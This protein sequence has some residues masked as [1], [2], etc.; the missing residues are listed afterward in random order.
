[1]TPATIRPLRPEDS[2]QAVRVFHDA[3]MNG[4][5]THY[6]LAQR[7]AWA[8]PA[9]DI[10]GWRNRFDGIDGFAAEIGGKLVGFMTLDRDGYIDLAFVHSA[11]AGQG[12][13][14]TLHQAIVA[15][16]QDNGIQTLTT[17]ASERAMPF[18]A[19]LGWQV[20][21]RQRVE[22]RGVVLTNYRMSKRLG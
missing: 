4:A 21:Q 15:K 3:I 1:M 16:A 2:A 19:S 7:Q 10:A 17:Q 14:R 22:K 5:A 18:F 6:T 9:P 11:F 12:I 8:G 20:G 13:G